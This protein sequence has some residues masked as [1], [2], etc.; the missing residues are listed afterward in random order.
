MNLILQ[1][2]KT[3]PLFQNLTEEE[4]QSI[5]AHITMQYFP[6]HYVLFEKGVP[7]HAMYIIKS[8]MIRIYNEQ[9][10]VASLG[11]GD[12]FGEM[13]LIEDQPRNASAETL[14]D[15]EIFVLNKED[16]AALL[17]KSP[18]IL[19]KVKEAY[20]ARKQENAQ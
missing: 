11:E 17:Q 12:F 15:C 8:G 18:D 6:A 13:A 3:V 20:Q 14:S 9:A 1:I 2:L 4:H 16:F 7:G 5:I 10:D 19:R